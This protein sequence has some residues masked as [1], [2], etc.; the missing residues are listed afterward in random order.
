MFK[1]VE[2]GSRSATW[3]VYIYI[4]KFLIEQKVGWGEGLRVQ[5][6]EV[7]EISEKGN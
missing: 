5:G 2:L 4:Y 3:R 1:L 7:E 6:E